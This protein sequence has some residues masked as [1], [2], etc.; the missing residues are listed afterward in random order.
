[1][2]S[3]GTLWGSPCQPQTKTI[4]SVAALNELKLEQPE[5]NFSNKPAE[6]MSK[7][8]YGKIP[9]FEGSD[10]FKL[11]ESAT[12]A[13]YLSGI[14][15]KINLLGSDA[16]EIALVDQWIH[17]AEQEIGGPC[18]NVMGLV[19]GF[20]GAFNRE[21]LDKQVERLV[22]AMTYVE[23][24]LATRPSGYLVSESVTLADVVLAGMV[25]GCSFAALGA[26]ERAQYPAVFAHYAKVT[27][28]EKVK[29]FWG[30]EGFT[31]IAVTEP[32][33]FPRT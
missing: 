24:H 27:E 30:T 29:Q 22:R 14:G 32:K 17:F 3:I 28:N 15:T 11:I 2:A 20:A 13:R 26:A 4:L 25:F 18:H 31:E 33:S 7:F 12:I 5:W 10:G 8:P 21:A 19:F 1:M 9:A 23:S 16:K 6:F